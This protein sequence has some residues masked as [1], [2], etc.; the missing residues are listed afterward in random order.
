ML[1]KDHINKQSN[2]LP[3][4]NTEP[5]MIINKNTLTKK[6]DI[7]GKKAKKNAIKILTKAKRSRAKLKRKADK[8]LVDIMFD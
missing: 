8:E 6:D 4:D 5:Y 3:E 2:V 1:L 7:Y